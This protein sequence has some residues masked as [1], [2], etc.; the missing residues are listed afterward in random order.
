MSQLLSTKVKDLPKQKLQKPVVLDHRSSTYDAIK[1]LQRRKHHAAPVLKGKE[2]LGFVDVRD[3][4][5]ALLAKISGGRLD[6]NFSQ[7]QTAFKGPEFAAHV[8]EFLKAPVER[9]VNAS[10]VNKLHTF[11]PESTLSEVIEEMKIFRLHH[12]AIVQGEEVVSV[13]SASDIIGFLAA[14]EKDWK[15]DA[16]VA[17]IV[18]D[19][20]E[21]PISVS[22]TAPA[23]EAFQLMQQN[24]MSGVAVT[25]ADGSLFA[26]FSASDIKHFPITPIGMNPDSLFMPLQLFLL[27]QSPVRA[28][29]AVKKGDTIASVVSKMALFHVHRVWV[30][31]EHNKPVAVVT[32]TEVFKHVQP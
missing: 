27:S 30:V 11:S 10:L 17:A 1:T 25:D 24:V 32:P 20:K 19:Q 26:N 28:P 14:H 9:I 29:V 13:L 12:A 15:G 3:I 6:L 16:Q 22:K 5:T 2:L 21:K 31:D 23:V 18:A 4:M 7:W 8:T